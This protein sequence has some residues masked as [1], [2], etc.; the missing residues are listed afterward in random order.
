MGLC[1]RDRKE[2][3]MR[4]TNIYT[5]RIEGVVNGFNFAVGRDGQ[6]SC[7]NLLSDSLRD[8]I[9]SAAELQFFRAD[10]RKMRAVEKLHMDGRV[11]RRRQ[12]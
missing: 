1:L 8:K 6:I 4:L 12:A 7:E 9:R 11:I 2:S 10:R 5:N 3:D